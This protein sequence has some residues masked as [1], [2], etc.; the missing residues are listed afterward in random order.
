LHS[1][2]HHIP[3]HKEL[4]MRKPIVVFCFFF[5]HL[6]AEA[7]DTTGLMQPRAIPAIPPTPFLT[8]NSTVEEA[9]SKI[10]QHAWRGRNLV[11]D[12]VRGGA[13]LLPLF[14]SVAVNSMDRASSATV[15]SLGDREE[16]L[17]VV[18]A[19]SEMA[20]DT[21]W[22]IVVRVAEGHPSPVVRGESLYEISRRMHQR[23]V[24]GANQPNI[25]VLQA[26]V[27]NVDDATPVPDRARTIQE[28]ALEGLASWTGIDFGAVDQVVPSSNE[29]GTT[30]ADRA[31][32]W[33]KVNTEML[34]WDKGVGRFVVRSR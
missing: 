25:N 31:R 16:V 32:A 12:L 34:V 18:L 4:V 1:P 13:D 21:S 24:S 33:L 11:E 27:A 17:P 15:D 5:S 20:T 3:Y 9:T 28:L 30:A 7:Q 14:R 23:C 19:L 22:G 29:I 2:S 6:L 8:S 10:R 26:L